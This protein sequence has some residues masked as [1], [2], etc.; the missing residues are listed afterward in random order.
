MDPFLCFAGLD[1]T[2]AFEAMQHEFIEKVD[3]AGTEIIVEALYVAREGTLHRLRPPWLVDKTR[4]TRKNPITSWT[5]RLLMLNVHKQICY[6][7]F[8]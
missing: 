6:H 2:E 3:Y 5:C 4:W 8:W 1:A 7:D